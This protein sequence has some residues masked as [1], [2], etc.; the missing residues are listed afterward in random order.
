MSTAHLGERKSLVF[1]ERVWLAPMKPN[2]KSQGLNLKPPSQP[3]KHSGMGDMPG[4]WGTAVQKQQS[5]CSHG[6][7]R[8]Q[9]GGFLPSHLPYEPQELCPCINQGMS[10]NL[11]SWL[12]SK[13][14]V[15]KLRAVRALSSVRC[16][17]QEI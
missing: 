5:Y 8:M 14:E 15:P 3:L 9:N 17:T 7:V 16:A 13:S 4:P 1:S 12:S 2:S 6:V 10:S 11:L